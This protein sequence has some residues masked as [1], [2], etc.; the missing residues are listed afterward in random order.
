MSHRLVPDFINVGCPVTW[1]C[2]SPD[3]AHR[4]THW[5]LIPS[6]CHLLCGQHW[7]PIFCETLGANHKN[8]QIYQPGSYSTAPAF[9]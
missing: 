5:L 2:S 6:P 3:T 8:L 1:I 7:T 4:Q 9:G